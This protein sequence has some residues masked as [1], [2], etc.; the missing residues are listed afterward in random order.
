MTEPFKISLFNHGLGVNVM[1]VKG[2][3]P[4]EVAKIS[5]MSIP[6]RT[7][8]VLDALDKRNGNTGTCWHNGYGVYSVYTLLNYPTCVFVEIGSGCD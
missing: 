6:E 4:E 3:T 5:M 8:A 2:F 1:K 7:K